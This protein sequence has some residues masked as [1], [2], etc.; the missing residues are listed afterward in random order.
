MLLLPFASLGELFSYKRVYVSGIVVFSAGSLLCALAP[1]FAAL[2]V[3]R[4]VQGVGAAMLMS[5]NTSLVKLIYPR[6]HLGE[7]SGSTPRWWP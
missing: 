4:T 7:G 5:V 6:R 2:V 3:A 1:S